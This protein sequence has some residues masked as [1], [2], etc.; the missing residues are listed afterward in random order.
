MHVFQLLLKYLPMQ[1]KFNKKNTIGANSFD[2]FK[3]IF[4]LLTKII[5][6]FMKITLI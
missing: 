6:G 3:I 1:K 2:G 5:L 4:A